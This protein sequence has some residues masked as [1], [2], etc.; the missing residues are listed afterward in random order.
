MAPK[1]RTGNIAAVNH[2][3]RAR[4]RFECDIP[5]EAKKVSIV[6]RSQSA[7]R[8]KLVNGT[9]PPFKGL[10]EPEIADMERVLDEI[11]VLLPVL[12]FDVLRPAGQ[13]VAAAA[14]G[15]SSTLQIS[16][17][18]SD[19]ATF[20]FTEVGTDAKAREASGEFVVLAGSVARRNEVPSCEEGIKRRRARLVEEG[21]AN[22]R[23]DPT[24]E[25]SPVCLGEN[26]RLWRRS[27]PRA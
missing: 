3:S 23:D 14:E 7:G 13:E 22:G 8:A 5:G 26:S 24:F 25:I 20:I 16:P 6:R 17:V 2:A 15:K 1:L 10:P 27:A 4:R 18:S 12:G 11:E 19:D 9:E 21:A